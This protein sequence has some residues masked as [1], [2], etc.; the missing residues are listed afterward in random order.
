M[1][2]GKAI[3]VLH[4]MNH[5]MEEPDQKGLTKFINYYESTTPL[6]R[7]A[8]DDAFIALTGFNLF[9]LINHSIKELENGDY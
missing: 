7:E 6:I 3:D 8:I 4:K 9:L 1:T 2:Y 5:F